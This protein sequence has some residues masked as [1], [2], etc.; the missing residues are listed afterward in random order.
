LSEEFLLGKNHVAFPQV[1]QHDEDCGVERAAWEVWVPGKRNFSL[2]VSEQ[3]QQRDD[4]IFLPLAL[5]LFREVEERREVQTPAFVAVNEAEQ[6]HVL[7][8]DDMGPRIDVGRRG[9]LG[10]E[11]DDA[12]PAY[13]VFAACE[14]GVLGHGEFLQDPE[15]APVFCAE[16]AFEVLFHGVQTGFD[17]GDLVGVVAVVCCGFEGLCVGDVVHSIAFVL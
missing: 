7:A 5:G 8:C 9:D 10:C 12:P 4:T 16:D 3:A 13:F 15:A 17:L 1:L 6:P 2:S 14:R 11:V